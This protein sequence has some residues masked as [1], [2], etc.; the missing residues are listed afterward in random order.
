[1]MVTGDHALTAEAIARDIGI[2]TLPTK[3]EIAVSRGVDPASISYDDP[4]LGAIVLSGGELNSLTEDEW[5]GII[6]CPEIVFA[7]TTPEQKLD[8]VQR[9]Q[10]AGEIVA[11]TGDG[12][13]DS[14][15]LKRAHIGA[16]MGRPDASDVAR[17]SADIVL[18]DDNFVSVVN[19]CE[20]GRVLFDNL[21]KTIA[22]TLSHLWPEIVPVLLNLIL[23][24]PLGLGPLLVLIVDLGTELAPAVSMAFEESEDAVMQRPPRDLSKDKLVSTPLLF[25]SYAV[26][27]VLEVITCFISYAMVFWGEDIGLGELLYTAKDYWQDNADAIELSAGVFTSEQ[28]VDIRNRAQSAWFLTLVL[29]QFFHVWFVRRRTTLNGSVLSFIF[30]NALLVFGAILEIAIAVICVYVPWLQPALQTA[31]IGA[32]HWV[33]A[34]GFAVVIAAFSSLR[35]H[36]SGINATCTAGRSLYAW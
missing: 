8:I 4:D 9:F 12:V 29:C 25:Y 28:Q 20:E 14:P 33:P 1:M 18:M 21:K 6:Q 10:D 35:W 2:I 26:V 30:S 31:S 15:A 23:G 3:T 16:A 7:R 27:G 22:Y 32:I 34:L 17:E 24:L 11:V 19:A 36:A 13:N 5:N